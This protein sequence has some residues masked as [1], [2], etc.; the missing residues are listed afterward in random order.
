MK[1]QS[2][3]N[4]LSFLVISTLFILSSIK[5][6][7]AQEYNLVFDTGLLMQQIE[8]AVRGWDAYKTMSISKVQQ[9]NIQV[10]TVPQAI[11]FLQK[12]IFQSVSTALEASKEKAPI[13]ITF[14]ESLITVMASSLI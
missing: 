2:I 5:F 14:T 6:S 10:L 8:A 12:E 13:S 4:K 9:R 11:E 3:A 1:N 7:Y